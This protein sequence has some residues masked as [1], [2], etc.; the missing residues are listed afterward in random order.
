MILLF[1]SGGL[2]LLEMHSHFVLVIIL[3]AFYLKLQLYYVVLVLLILM[4]MLDGMGFFIY[5][6]FVCVGFYANF[7]IFWSY[8][9]NRFTKPA[10]LD[11]YSVVTNISAS[12]LILK[13]DLWISCEKYC[14]VWGMK[15]ATPGL[16]IWCCLYWGNRLG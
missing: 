11:N 12:E 4:M 2:L 6:I 7:H 16:Q 3:S 1:I 14:L 9:G 8:L 10:F 13:H 15:P 5:F